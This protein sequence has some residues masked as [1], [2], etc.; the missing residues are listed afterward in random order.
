M[1]AHRNLLYTRRFCWLA[2][3]PPAEPE[4]VETQPELAA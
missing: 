4:A 1:S 3:L 2:Y